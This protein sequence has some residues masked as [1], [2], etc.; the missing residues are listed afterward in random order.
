MKSTTKI[1]SAPRSRTLAPLILLGM[2]S[3]AYWYW[4]EAHGA[5]DLRPYALVQFLPIVLIPIILLLFKSGYLNGAL[6]LWALVLY[7]VAKIF[8]QFDYEIFDAIG[9][10]SGHAI[11]HGV[12]AIAVLLIIRAVPALPHS[13]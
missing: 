6:L 3:V 8:E 9:F 1:V 11:K 12:A 10:V 5:G 13:R 2:G 7:F 4:T